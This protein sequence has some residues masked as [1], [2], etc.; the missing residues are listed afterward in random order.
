[1]AGLVRTTA[2]ATT[3]VS[4]AEARAQCRLVSAGSPP[5]HPQ[6]SL[7]SGYLQAAVDELDG[8]EGWL[9]RALVTQVW[10]LHLDAFPAGAIRLPL[11]PL[12]SVDQVSYIDTA[13]DTQVL[14]P[15]TDYR[16]VADADPVALVE[17]AW[18]TSWPATRGI[19]NAVTVAFT[20]GYG[21]AAGDVP[22]LIRNYILVWVAL[23]YQYPAP[24]LSGTIVTEVPWLRHALDA[25]YR[26]RGA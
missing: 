6:D 9:G 15:D 22:E 3:P 11:P 20:C 2:P 1:M 17:P 12:Q 24:A 10:A 19:A 21:D 25:G 5:S 23:R 7:L 14:V 4:L 13:G 8:A 16:V 26:V 18:G